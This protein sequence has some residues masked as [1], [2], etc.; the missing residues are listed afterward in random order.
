MRNWATTSQTGART[1]V[2]SFNPKIIPLII[3][4]T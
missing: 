1:L 2:S 3:L 4:T